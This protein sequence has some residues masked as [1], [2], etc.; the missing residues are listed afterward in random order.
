M[1]EIINQTRFVSAA[2]LKST[3][4]NYVKIYNR[5]IP[6]RALK[7]QT[8]IQV[9]KNWQQKMPDLFVKRVYN[10]AGLDS[11]LIVGSTTTTLLRTSSIPVFL[12][13]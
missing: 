12:L 8:P 6:Q 7:H 2:K 13:R 11:Q 9:L 1:N 3:L 10:P 5:N 4:R